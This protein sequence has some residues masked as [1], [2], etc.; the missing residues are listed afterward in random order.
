MSRYEL[1]ISPNYVKNWGVR[2]AARELFQNGFDAEISNP[3]NKFTYEMTER[4][5][6]FTNKKSVL[7]KSSLLF[8]NTTKTTG[9]T[10]GSFG[11]GYKLALM[12]LLRSGL[13]VVIYNYACKETWTPKIIQSKRYGSKLL[14][15]DI[16]KSIFK[17]QNQNLT[18]QVL[19]LT[20]AEI[21][22]IRESVLQ[23]QPTYA[24]HNTDLGQILLNDNH[25]SKIFVGGLFVCSNKD[26]RYGYNFNPGVITVDRD[27]CLVDDFQTFWK[28]SSVW[29]LVDDTQLK[30]RLVSDQVKDVKYINSQGNSLKLG[31]HVTQ[32][33]QR[34][35]G[36]DAIP[37][38]NQSNLEATSAT[39]KG[40]PIIVSEQEKDMIVCSS[41]YVPPSPKKEVKLPHV[42]LG[43]WLTNHRH[44]LYQEAIDDF[45]LII[46]KS[47]GW[48]E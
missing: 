44:V 22:K 12:V 35:Y 46:T 4:Q 42:V 33:F 31:N 26:L 19:G 7:E 9:E 24:H 10:V 29:N 14:V 5:I 20:T 6:T 25:K 45:E 2:E 3:D 48:Y 18:I 21:S 13:S 28:T 39:Y 47:E 8:G 43:E 30:V 17:K 41:L 27:R 40:S 32:R 23:T 1:S 15:I 36:K 11:E 37:V 38:T 34:K 16:T